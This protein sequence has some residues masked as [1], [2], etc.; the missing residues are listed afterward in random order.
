MR[1][2]FSEESTFVIG[3]VFLYFKKIALTRA[4]LDEK[5]LSERIIKPEGKEKNV[6]EVRTNTNGFFQ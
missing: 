6:S 2:F 5:Y 4:T 3:L 1:F